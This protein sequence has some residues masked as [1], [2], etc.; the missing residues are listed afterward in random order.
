MLLGG[1]L[2]GG[3]YWF[4]RRE[5]LPAQVGAGLLNES[6]V[7]PA[8]PE[9]LQDLPA[10]NVVL[11]D[12]LGRRALLLQTDARALGREPLVLQ[13]LQVGAEGRLQ[14]AGTYRVDPR[15]NTVTS[16]R[17]T[18]VPV[19]IDPAT[20][21]LRVIRAGNLVV[22]SRWPNASVLIDGRTRGPAPQRL[23][24]PPGRH[25]VRVEAGTLHSEVEIHLPEGETVS[26]I[27]G[28][29]GPPR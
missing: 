8:T 14:D 25:T 16:P 18:E 12:R 7:E 28:P 13:G 6:P 11:V 10:G 2:L 26:L 5:A 9:Q 17:G 21:S 24:L 20:G 1:A 22:S 3:G 15:L 19:E 4:G 29:T 23:L 27:L